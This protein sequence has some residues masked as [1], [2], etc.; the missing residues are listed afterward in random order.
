MDF[1][2][3]GKKVVVRG[4]F[5]HFEESFFINRGILYF[6]GPDLCSWCF[7]TMSEAG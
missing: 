2:V 6:T 3:S 7:L 4:S 5:S 1:S